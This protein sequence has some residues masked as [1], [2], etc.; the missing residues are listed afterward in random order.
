MN[1]QKVPHRDYIPLTFQRHTLSLE[2]NLIL[3]FTEGGDISTFS[4]NLICSWYV[5]LSL[6][7]KHMA[8]IHPEVEHTLLSVIDW[9]FYYSQSSSAP[10]STRSK[11]IW[12]RRMEVCPLNCHGFFQAIHPMSYRENLP[13]TLL[14]PQQHYLGNI[15]KPCIIQNN[16][17]WLQPGPSTYRLQGTDL[18]SNQ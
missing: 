15:L 8:A 2:N 10:V 6:G 16:V 3:A 5:A 13:L 17:P 11:P 18:D 4:I 14:S 1:D 7:S 9:N 12:A